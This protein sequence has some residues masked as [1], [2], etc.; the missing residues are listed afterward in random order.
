MLLVQLTVSEVPL[1]GWKESSFL[2][3]LTVITN[4]GDENMIIAA[5]INADGTLVRA[6]HGDI[7]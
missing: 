4:E 3:F 2:T 1:T 5:S 6:S 7:R